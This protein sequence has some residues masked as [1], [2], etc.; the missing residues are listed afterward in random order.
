[1]RYAT[2]YNDEVI[3]DEDQLYKEWY[4]GWLILS[5]NSFRSATSMVEGSYVSKAMPNNR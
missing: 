2:T 4:L 3:T 1:M 5:K